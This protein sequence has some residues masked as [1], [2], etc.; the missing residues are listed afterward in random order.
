VLG[1]DEDVVTLENFAYGDTPSPGA[2]RRLLDDLSAATGTFDLN[3]YRTARD[4]DI[5]PLVLSTA[6]TYLELE[7]RLRQLTPFYAGYRVR[8]EER[9]RGAVAE[10]PAEKAAFVRAAFRAAKQGRT[11]FTF[12]MERVPEALGE[13]RERIVAMIDWL[14][15]AGLAEVRP[16]DVRQRYE[17]LEAIDP[18]AEAERLH[19]RFL[20]QEQREVARVRP[21][22]RLP[23][24]RP[25][26]D[27][28]DPGVLRGDAGRALRPLRRLRDGAG[29]HPAP[30]PSRPPITVAVDR[31]DVER[32]A[33]EHPEAL[34]EPRQQARFLCGLS[35]P[36]I[37]RELKRERLHGALEGYPFGEVLAW[38]ER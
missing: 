18:A 23:G 14:G 1:S 25:L 32:L 3:P 11:W 7:G 28:G 31:G 4:H 2:L 9:M 29:R 21:H 37:G 38:C 16:S 24:H 5:R 8:P 20:D 10:M 27:R 6:L 36:A 33:Q 22:G 12:D 19:A 26:P 15:T 17:W 13:S 30:G 35:S 34:G